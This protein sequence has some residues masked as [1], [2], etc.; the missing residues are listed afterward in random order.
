MAADRTSEEGRGQ[1][2]AICRVL[3]IADPGT[4]VAVGEE[5]AHVALF[6]ARALHITAFR[7][8]GHG[9]LISEIGRNTTISVTVSLCLHPYTVRLCLCQLQSL[10]ASIIIIVCLSLLLYLSYTLWHCQSQTL[11]RLPVSLQSLTYISHYRF[12]EQHNAFEQL[13]TVHFSS[14]ERA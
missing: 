3:R 11:S 4:H 9:L 2:V 8:I 12:A 6:T 10:S 5:E 14:A 1:I 7:G 13:H